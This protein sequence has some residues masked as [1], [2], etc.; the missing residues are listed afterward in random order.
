MGGEEGRVGRSGYLRGAGVNLHVVR[1]GADS[2]TPVILLHGF[3]EF[4]YSWRRQIGALA[5]AGFSV[6]APDLRGYNLSEKPTGVEAYRLPLLVAD[7]A[8]LVRAVGNGRRAHVVGHDWGGIIAWTF[9]GAYP[10]LVDRLAVLNAPHPRLFLDHLWRSPPQMIR[11]SYALFF[12]LPFLPERLLAARDFAAVRGMLRRTPWRKGA[13]ADADLTEYA[14]ALSR[15]GA[16]TAAL[17]Y[18]R[19]AARF[20]RETRRLACAA[21]TD[22]E[23]LVIWGERDIALGTELLDGLE[24]FAPRVRIHRL[25]DAGHWVQNEAPEEVNRALLAFLTG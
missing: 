12:Q 9:A 4:W 13:F 10:D 8:A 24:G 19:A 21:T 18:Y 6:L 16:L 15:P 25:P 20:S 23:T 14:A 17:N 11:S 5:D 7:V 1:A 2:A 3:P 22:A